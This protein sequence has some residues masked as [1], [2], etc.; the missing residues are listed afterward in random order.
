MTDAVQFLVAMWRSLSVLLVLCLIIWFS[1]VWGVFLFLHYKSF[2]IFSFF[3][4][5]DSSSYFSLCESQTVLS[6]WQSVGASCT[7]AFCQSVIAMSVVSVVS[8]LAGTDS[9]EYRLVPGWQATQ[10]PVSWRWR[11]VN[12]VTCEV[13]VHGSMGCR[14]AGSKR[15]ISD[16]TFSQLKHWRDGNPRF[17]TSRC[18]HY[19]LYSMQWKISVF[20]LASI[21]SF[22]YVC[23][24]KKQNVWRFLAW[25]KLFSHQQPLIYSSLLTLVIGKHALNIK[26]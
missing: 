19:E 10:Q 11:S 5:L 14:S 18:I 7:V 6:C 9:S 20:I 2:H 24:L 16:G 17:S 22:V 8:V 23:V 3:W 25:I 12:C 13:T 26:L 1:V 21:M 4:L 15:K